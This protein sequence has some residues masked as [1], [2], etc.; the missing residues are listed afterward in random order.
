LNKTLFYF[1]LFIFFQ[2]I[3]FSPVKSIVLIKM[4]K[5]GLSKE[6]LVQIDLLV[7]FIGNFFAFYTASVVSSNIKK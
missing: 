3:G 5:D 1:I 2:N 7:T 6:I 4:Q